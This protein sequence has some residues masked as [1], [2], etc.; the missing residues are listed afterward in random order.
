MP[1]PKPVNAFALMAPTGAAKQE[2]DRANAAADLTVKKQKAAD[3]ARRKKAR[4]AEKRRVDEIN[5]V[6]AERKRQRGAGPSTATGAAA[7]AAVP[8]GA[9]PEPAIVV[10]ESVD[11]AQ[12]YG[13]EA[14]FYVNRKPPFLG[15]SDFE[16]REVLRGTH[17]ARWVP[18]EKLWGAPTTG[19]LYNL[20]QSGLWHPLDL[21]E[22]DC[23][24]LLA[25]L[26]AR[27]QRAQAKAV[28]AADRRRVLEAEEKRRAQELAEARRLDEERRAAAQAAEEAVRVE[29]LRNRTNALPPEPEERDAMVRLGVHAATVLKSATW[30]SLGPNF[31]ISLEARIVRYLDLLPDAVCRRA[32]VAELNASAANDAPFVWTW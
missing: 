11:E 32:A 18:S 9:A 2:L 27:E 24:Q 17:G 8:V 5:A 1:R 19:V 12:L 21:S 25:L 22:A 6:L 29:A 7:A 10:E 3:A 20:V 15:E 26:A 23:A 13:V 4:D 31:G 14:A 28:A 30:D 16:D